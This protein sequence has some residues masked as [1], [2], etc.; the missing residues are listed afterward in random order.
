MYDIGILK[1]IAEKGG[2]KES[3]KLSTREIS[4]EVNRSPQT[5]SRRL[6]ELEAEGMISRRITPDGQWI[7]ITEKGERTLRKEYEG[8]RRIFE[9][10]EILY[11][12]GKVFTGLGEG[13]YYLSLSGYINQISRIIGFQPYPG[14]L[15]IR[16]LPEDLEIRRRLS[17]KPGYEIKGFESEGR[18]FGDCKLFIGEVES[19][20]C[21][22]VIPERTHYPEDVLEI[23]APLNLRDKLG[24]GDG[25]I[26][27]LKVIA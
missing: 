15:N 4:S 16:V 27:R 1:F 3:V 5:V 11:I 18:K 9:S 26:I 20:K 17:K 7:A 19:I 23:I 10:S 8:Y 14:T 22:V 2:M 6:K 21:G 12:R 24:L 13:R 25:D